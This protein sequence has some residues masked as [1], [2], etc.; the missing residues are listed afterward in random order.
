MKGSK[1]SR[2]YIEEI[3]ACDWR[4]DGRGQA[5]RPL[6]HDEGDAIMGTYDRK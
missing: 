1:L 4:A 6:V 5:A 2:W 3:G